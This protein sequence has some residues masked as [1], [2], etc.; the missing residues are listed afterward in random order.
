MIRRLD[1]GDDPGLEAFPVAER[2]DRRGLELRP[3]EAPASP[4]GT[5]QFTPGPQPAGSAQIVM[6]Q[7]TAAPAPAYVPLTPK[8]QAAQEQPASGPFGPKAGPAATTVPAV[9]YPAAASPYLPYAPAAAPDFFSTLPSWAMPV[10]IGAGA[11]LVLVL[12]MRRR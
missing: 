6:I 5:T 9:R 1:P 8:E 11:L 7:S 2:V 3:A 10:A 4:T 12:L